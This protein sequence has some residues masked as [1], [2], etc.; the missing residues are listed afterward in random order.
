MRHLQSII[1]IF[2]QLHALN[3]EQFKSKGCGTFVVNIN[4]AH[5]ESTVLLAEQNSNPKDVGHL[6][7]K[8]LILSQLFYLLNKIQIQRMWNICA[9]NANFES[10]V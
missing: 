2:S 5:F 6:Q 10:T 8:M 9:N 4:N 1:L 7:P 3:A